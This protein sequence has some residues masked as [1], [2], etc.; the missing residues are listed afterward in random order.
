[1]LLTSQGSLGGRLLSDNHTAMD[2]SLVVTV[3]RR[4]EGFAFLTPAPDWIELRADLAG[5]L[6]AA[7]LRSLTPAT[8]LY[9]LRGVTEGRRERLLRAASSFDLIDLECSDLGDTLLLQRIRPER[10]V[11]TW[12]GRARTMGDLDAALRAVQRVPARRCRLEVE[13]RGCSEAVLPMALLK[14]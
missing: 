9:T 7:N 8:L 5:D 11:I 1:M 3:G 2:A 6:D 10:R 12:R 4:P 14:P 13:A